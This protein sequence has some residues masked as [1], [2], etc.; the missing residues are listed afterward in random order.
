MAAQRWAKPSLSC[1]GPYKRKKTRLDENEKQMMAALWMPGFISSGKEWHRTPV[2]GNDEVECSK[3]N[4]SSSPS[5]ARW[6]Q[7][8]GASDNSFWDIELEG[9]D[10]STPAT[11]PEVLPILNITNEEQNFRSVSNEQAGEWN[12][13][14][15]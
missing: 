6:Q 9:F 15:G 13:K 11:K 5:S 7:F 14:F 1:G 10:N 4:K 8:K 3:I 12:T 2:L